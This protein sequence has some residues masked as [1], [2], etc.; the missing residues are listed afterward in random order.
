MAIY[1]AFAFGFYFLLMITL[2]LGWM[3]AINTEANP[4]LSKNIFISVV[5]AMRNERQNLQLLFQSLVNQNYPLSNFEI[6]VVDDHSSV[7]K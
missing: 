7:T 1:F 6:I 3:M 4:S 2:W 5:I